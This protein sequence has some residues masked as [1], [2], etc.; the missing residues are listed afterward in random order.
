M[1]GHDDLLSV[2]PWEMHL[3]SLAAL[4]LTYAAI[5]EREHKSAKSIERSFERLRDKLR[6]RGG[7]TKAGLVH[8]FDVNSGNWRD[9]VS[10]CAGGLRETDR[11]DS[12]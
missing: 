10:R 7:G 1:I 9:A 2:S 11:A 5:A 12:A 3:L 4:G 6:P 8:W